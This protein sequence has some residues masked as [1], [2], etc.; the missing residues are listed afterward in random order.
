MEDIMKR[1]ALLLSGFV[2]TCTL[3]L[4][5]PAAASASEGATPRAAHLQRVA[6]YHVISVNAEAL[7]RNAPVVRPFDDSDGLTRN[8]DECN[9]GC[10]DNEN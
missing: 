9:S 4:A 6:H 7:S 1:T 3:A 5:I 10:I 8:R 2:L